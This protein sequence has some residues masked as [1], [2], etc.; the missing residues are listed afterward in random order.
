MTTTLNQVGFIVNIEYLDPILF[1]GH[2]FC[3]IIFEQTHA[4]PHKEAVLIF[5]LKT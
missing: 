5:R 3:K 2:Q 1:P 4:K